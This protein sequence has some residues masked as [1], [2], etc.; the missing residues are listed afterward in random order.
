LARILG[1]SFPFTGVRLGNLLG[2]DFDIILPGPSIEL[3]V[4]PIYQHPKL[5]LEA[6]VDPTLERTESESNL[7][8]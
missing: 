2:D 5:A 8:N 4:P 1:G 7:D 3:G 6:W